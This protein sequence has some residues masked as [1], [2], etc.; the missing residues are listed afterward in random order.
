MAISQKKRIRHELIVLHSPQQYG[1]AERMNRTLVESARS[2]VAHAGVSNIF[3]A[4]AISTAAYVRN[5]LPTTVLK[6]NETPYERCYGKK[7]EQVNKDAFRGLQF[8][9]KGISSFVDDTNRKLHI[10]RDVEFNENESHDNR[11]RPKG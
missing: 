6:E 9:V 11:A 4:E 1:V 3:W 2:M 8:D 7:P 5:R 10:R